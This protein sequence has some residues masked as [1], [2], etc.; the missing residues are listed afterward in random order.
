M[1]NKY[2]ERLHNAMIEAAVCDYWE[3]VILDTDWSEN[4]EHSFSKRHIAKINAIIRKH[5]LIVMRKKA[6]RMCSKAAV[7][8]LV[9]VSVTFATMMSSSAMRE[10]V[11]K[12]ISQMREFFSQVIT[13][14]LTVE[15]FNEIQTDTQVSQ[16]E[17]SI[18]SALKTEGLPQDTSFQ[19]HI[20]GYLNMRLTGLDDSETAKILPYINHAGVAGI[21]STAYATEDKNQLYYIQSIIRDYEALPPDRSQDLQVSAWEYRQIIRNYM[22]AHDIKTN[23]EIM[24]QERTIGYKNGKLIFVK[25]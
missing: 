14:E 12:I 25:E 13:G 2:S 3:K 4:G 9:F 1:D 16:I 5:K 6:I 24:E 21:L 18:S 11:Y 19:I 20:D 10:E 8:I 17:E 7:I 23:E 15:Q 22:F